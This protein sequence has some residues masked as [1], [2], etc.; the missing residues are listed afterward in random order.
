M[1]VPLCK[2]AAIPPNARIHVLSPASFA[3]ND[4]V[5]RGLARLRTLG[6]APHLA[7][8]AQTRGPLFFAGSAEERLADLHTAFAD[9]ETHIVAA[10]RGGYGSNYLLND[11]DLALIERQAKPF[12]AYS[13]LTGLQLHLLDRLGLPIFHGPMVAADFALDDGVHLPSFQSALAGKPYS[14]GPAEGLRTLKPGTARGTLYGGC[15]SILVAMLGT[16]WAPATEGKLLF[17][18]DVGVKPYQIDRM[19]WQLRAA[20]KF[21]GIRGIVFGEMLDCTSPGAFA[22][23]LDD[24]IVHFFRYTNIPIAIGLRSGHVSHANVTLTFGAEAELH[25]PAEPHLNLVEPVIL[26]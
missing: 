21:E 1:P 14:L 10:V 6:F 13:D 20:G 19:L 24:V 26:S 5:E 16:P 3:S 4:R 8:H 2:L 25:A 7:T 9:P 17:L 15:L 22:G 12:F 18:E 11:L 23:L